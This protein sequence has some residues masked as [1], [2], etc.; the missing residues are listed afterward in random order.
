M[1]DRYGRKGFNLECILTYNVDE[2][3]CILPIFMSISR[4]KYKET[5]ACTKPNISQD[6]EYLNSYIRDDESIK[7][8]WISWKFSRTSQIVQLLNDFLNCMS[9]FYNHP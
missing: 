2:S 4:E 6:V 7:W 1:S 5:L 8:I 3:Y 9:A